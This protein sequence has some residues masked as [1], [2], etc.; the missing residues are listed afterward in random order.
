M[1]SFFSRSR[2]SSNVS[3]VGATQ[4]ESGTAGSML[5]G[6]G[7]P[8]SNSAPGVGVNDQVG[9]GGRNGPMPPMPMG[10]PGDAAGDISGVNSGINSGPAGAN[11]PNHKVCF[12]FVNFIYG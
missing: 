3:G 5:G 12:L 8:V 2:N 7:V 11:A 4:L 10:G 9:V 1:G 6:V